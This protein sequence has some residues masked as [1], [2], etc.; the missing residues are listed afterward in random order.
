MSTRNRDHEARPV[1]ADVPPE[2]GR[3][4]AWVQVTA[5]PVDQGPEHRRS[6]RES[7]DCARHAG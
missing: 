4:S 6:T 7:G 1:P 2:Q 5:R 3:R